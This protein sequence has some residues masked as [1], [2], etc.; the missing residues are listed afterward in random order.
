[1]DIFFSALAEVG[2]L[3][4]YAAILGMVAPYVLGANDDYGIVLPASLSLIGGL[5]LWALL[6]WVGMP[7]NN[8]FTWIIVMLAM[9]VAFAFVS[10][11]LNHTRDAEN[12]EFLADY[13][14]GGANTEYSGS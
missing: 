12:V 5:G 8:A 13:V 11:R 6:I 1:M 7:T 2:F 3:A 14:R 4:V 9:P 10:R